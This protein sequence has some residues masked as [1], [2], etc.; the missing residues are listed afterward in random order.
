M[1]ARSI[2]INC[3]KAFTLVMKLEI[4]SV[5]RL[6]VA[7]HTQLTALTLSKFSTAGSLMVTMRGSGC[8]S[9]VIV[10]VE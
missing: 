4:I 1:L 2:G 6:V 5:V 3:C 10:V 7:A 9:C 8:Y